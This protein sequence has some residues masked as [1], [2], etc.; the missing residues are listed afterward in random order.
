MNSKIIVL[1]QARCG[2]T[3][4][5]G[6]VLKEILGKP[7]ILQQLERIK[8]SK[9][10]DKIIVVTTENH[11]DD[12]LAKIVSES[13]FE[14]FRGSEND[15]LKRFY[16][17][18]T[19]EEAQDNDVIVR[20]T[21]DCPLHHHDII[22]ELVDSF[23]K[24]DLEYMMNRSK[25]PSGFDVEA[26]FFKLLKQAHIFAKDPYDREHV[27]PFLRKKDEYHFIKTPKLSVDELAEFEFVNNIFNH[28]KNNTFTFEDIVKYL[29]KTI[30]IRADNRPKS[31]LGH[32]MRCQV[33]A[34]QLRDNGYEVFF[35]TE[36]DDLYEMIKSKHASIVIFDH[37]DIGYEYEKEIQE[38]SGVKIFVIDD[39]YKKHYCDFLLNQNLYAQKEKYQNLVPNYC[40]IYCGMPLIRKEFKN[41]VKKDRATLEKNKILVTMGG[42]DPQNITAKILQDITAIKNISI[43]VVEKYVDAENMAQLMNEADIVITSGGITIF[44]LLYLNVPMICIA[45]AENQKQNVE[46]IKENKLGL[47]PKNIPQALNELIKN[48]K[49]RLELISNMRKIPWKKKNFCLG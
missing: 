19:K 45:I 14:V 25:Y 20:I 27:T 34:E 33:L 6:K 8:N 3:R 21:G 46:F 22:D 30:L 32:I 35:L 47:C 48:N 49:L 24:S 41:I 44:E 5:P 39:N 18:A 23:L 43:T 11:D 17:A 38:R 28:F 15:V 29:K 40:K 1:L 26:F 7:M 10:V 37:Y 36:K 16:D 31:G 4:L 42:A 2:S 9:F 13:G 12:L